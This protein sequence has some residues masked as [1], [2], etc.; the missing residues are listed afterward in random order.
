MLPIARV[1]VLHSRIPIHAHNWLATPAGCSV[2]LL[3]QSLTI[4]LHETDYR[5]LF[6][7]IAVK[8]KFE[9]SSPYYQPA[10]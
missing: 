8:A 2:A 6:E 1:T 10:Q 9:L 7:T 4:I 3:I 5:L